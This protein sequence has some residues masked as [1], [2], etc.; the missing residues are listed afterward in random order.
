LTGQQQPREQLG[1][2][3]IGLDP[4]ARGAGVLLGAATSI[5]IPAARAALASPK[6]LGPAS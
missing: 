3:A 1:V 2:L 5:S 4:V 6:P